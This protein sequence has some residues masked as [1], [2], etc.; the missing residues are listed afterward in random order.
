LITPNDFKPGLTIELDGRVLQIMS[1][2]H[3][4]QGRGD[5]IV[6]T[7]L[8]DVESGDIFTK[9]FRSNESI[10][11]AH[12]ERRDYQ[13]LYSTGEGYVFMDTEDYEQRELT[14]EILGDNI[15]WLKEGETVQL[16]LYQG[17]IIGLEVPKT[18]D[19]RVV[20]TDPGLRGDTAQGGAK[21][22]TIEGGAVVTVPLFV[23]TGDVIRVET[24]SGNYV[25]RVDK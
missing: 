9:T 22:A 10:E 12:V 17:K 4:K 24:S 25:G 5:A 3:H 11:R 16:A 2:E 6:R 14:P 7:R 18:V 23:Q 1:A 21:P 20:Q 19:R 8:R 15:K 13:Y